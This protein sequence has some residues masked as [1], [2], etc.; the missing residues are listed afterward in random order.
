MNKILL[1]LSVVFVATMS[2][3]SYLYWQLDDSELT[4]ETVAGAQIKDQNGNVVTVYGLSE[5][6]EYGNVSLT[7][8]PANTVLEGDTAYIIDTG[9]LNSSYSYYIELVNSSG[10]AVG[11]NSSNTI[12]YSDLVNSTSGGAATTAELSKT[13][14]SVWHTSGS[15]TNVHEPTSAMLM[16]FGVAFLG[17]KR[18][19]R[20]IA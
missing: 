7:A 18:K 11:D 3:A 15:V 6:D 12:T 16:M 17:L 19:N 10:T 8:M 1:M 5:P 9:D 20:S 4:G 13:T 14:A 2:N